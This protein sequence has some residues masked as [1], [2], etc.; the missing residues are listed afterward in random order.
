MLRK[1]ED[2]ALGSEKSV[3]WL[4]PRPSTLVKLFSLGAV[5]TLLGLSLWERS[6]AAVKQSQAA[7]KEAKAAIRSL[8]EKARQ[9]PEQ[10]KTLVEGDEREFL[11]YTSKPWPALAR[12]MQLKPALTPQIFQY[13]GI[14]SVGFLGSTLLN[15]LQ[16]AW[17]R[18]EESCIRSDLLGRLQN[19]FQGSIEAKI[20]QDDEH[21]TYAKEVLGK[22]LGSVGLQMPGLLDSGVAAQSNLAEQRNFAFMPQPRQQYRQGSDSRAPLLTNG[23]SG[24]EQELPWHPPEQLQTNQGYFKLLHWVKPAVAFGVTGFGA[25]TGGYI[26][27][28]L[29]TMRNT[30]KSEQLGKRAEA[31]WKAGKED[32][33]K[34]LIEQNLPKL[35]AVVKKTVKE[36]IGIND[37]EGLSLALLEQWQRLGQRSAVR[38]L[39][40]VYALSTLVG[41]GKLV[42]DG[43]REIEVTRLN[44]ETEL[45]YERYKWLSLDTMYHRIAER[46][47]LDHELQRFET[48][49][50]QLKANPAAAQQRA[51]NILDNIG[52]WS[53]PPYYPVTPTVQLAEARS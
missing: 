24:L 46:T 31:L 26:K 18:W 43:L 3:A 14:A 12:M 37:M 19:A 9:L 40:G 10:G 42:I 34:R 23:S 28:C 11:M 48:D 50:P 25:L 22:L 5:G 33:A 35:Q 41:V 29:D 27:T 4:M 39:F 49:L 2:K 7:A 44:A 20:Q 45:N 36:T 53:P 38:S 21:R 52:L 8:T 13:M 6:P 47:Q 15:G 17:V 30:T 16:E 32:E 51:K 1:D